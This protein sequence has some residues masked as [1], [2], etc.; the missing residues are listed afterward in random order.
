MPGKT[1]TQNVL[2][3]LLTVSIFFIP[4]ANDLHFILYW[5][6]NLKIEVESYIFRI[7]LME[8]W[9][10]EIW[11]LGNWDDSFKI[12]D[13]NIMYGVSQF[14]IQLCNKNINGTR[15]VVY[16][17]SSMCRFSSKCWTWICG[18]WEIALKMDLL[19]DLAVNIFKKLSR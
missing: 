11:Y 14:I 8:S 9:N 5:F 4:H 13:I 7:P 6:C 1:D 2:H 12:F 18:S 16:T 10:L 15:N 17:Q 3:I 19:I